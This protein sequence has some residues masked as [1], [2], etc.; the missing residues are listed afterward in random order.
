MAND[1]GRM[2]GKRSIQGGR[3][4][5]RGALYMAA[6]GRQPAQSGHL[7]LLPAPPVTFSSRL[8]ALGKPKKL[9]LSAT[10]RQLMVHSSTVKPA[11]PYAQLVANLVGAVGHGPRRSTLPG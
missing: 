2:R 7:R 3:A 6:L 5:V 8:L 10:M 11:I 4:V 1:S 9:A